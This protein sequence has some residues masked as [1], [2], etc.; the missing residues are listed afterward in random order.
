MKF[1]LTCNDSEIFLFNVFNFDEEKVQ[2][3][4]VLQCPSN[5]MLCTDLK[6]ANKNIQYTFHND[7][8]SCYSKVDH[9]IL[10][11]SLQN[12]CDNEVTIHS[13]EDF[14]NYLPIMLNAKVEFDLIKSKTIKDEKISKPNY[15]QVSNW[16]NKYKG[17]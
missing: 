16:S 9:F 14:S 15:V 1:K 4:K 11:E 2:N 8:R 10:S 13:S 12:K 7:T 3:S 17:M 6:I 5:F